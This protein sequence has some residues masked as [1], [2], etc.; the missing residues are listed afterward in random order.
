MKRTILSNA[1]WWALAAALP[2][3][4][5]AALVCAYALAFLPSN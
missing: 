2:L 1:A 3:L 4:C 5:W